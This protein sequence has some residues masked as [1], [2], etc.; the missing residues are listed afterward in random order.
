MQSNREILLVDDEPAVLNALKRELRPYFPHLHT[1]TCAQEALELLK[2][3]PVQMVISDY[4]MPGMNGA[5]LVIE[6]NRRYPHIMS[7]ILSGQADMNGLSRA[8]NEG[9]CT[10]F[11]SSL[12]SEIIC[13]K[14]SCSVLVKKSAVKSLI[15][16]PDSKHGKHS[17]NKSHYYSHWLTTPILC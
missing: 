17:T 15:P 16:F 2:Q 3:H 13:C 11:C 9:D 10:N 6:I 5:D 14:Q 4:R 8:L 7:L 1:A 12:G